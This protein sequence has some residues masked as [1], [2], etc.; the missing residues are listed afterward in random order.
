MSTY[1]DNLRIELITTGTQAGTWG[2]TTNTNLG[3]IIE[4][5]IAG[6]AAVAVSSANQ[7]FTAVNGAADQA[8]CAIIELT[9]STGSTFAVYA[10]PVT[11]EYIIWNNS[12]YTATIY[13]STV[14]GNTTAAGTGVA[15]PAGDKVTV[16]SDGTNFYQ[17]GSSGTVTSVALSGGTTGLTV[18]GSPITSSGTITLAGT[19]VVANGGTGQTS[20]TDG[21]LLIGNTATGGLSK[22]TLTAGSNISITNGNGTIT[23]ASTG[24]SGASI[25]SGTSMLFVQ[26]SAPTGWTKST[27]HNNK[28]LRVVSGAASSGGSVD[29]TTAFASQTPSGSVSVSGTV[30][31]TTLSTSQIPSHSHSPITGTTGYQEWSAGAGSYVSATSGGTFAFYFSSATGSTGGGGSHNHSFSGSASFSGNAINLAVQYVDVIIATAN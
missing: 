7:A 1:S 13:N 17:A 16:F 28:A 15:I 2:T 30:G 4:D 18:S 19:L 27:T 21:Q 26:T 8:R 23:I 6:Y 25:P 22:A 3:T 9:T 24:A 31:S 5:S 20:Y 10:P 12:S 29:F 14:L 11:K